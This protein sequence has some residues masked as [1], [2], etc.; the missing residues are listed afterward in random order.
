MSQ[1]YNLRKCRLLYK[2]SLS[3][4]IWDIC[5]AYIDIQRLAL[6]I[7]CVYRG[8]EPAIEIYGAEFFNFG[9]A[10]DIWLHPNGTKVAV[11]KKTPRHVMSPNTTACFNH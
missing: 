2:L 9:S 10:C 3:S 6:Q 5:Q 4:S 11:L 7:L 8:S 1:L